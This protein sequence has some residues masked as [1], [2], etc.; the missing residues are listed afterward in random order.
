MSQF[1]DFLAEQMKDPE[2]SAAYQRVSTEID[3]ELARSIQ[4]TPAH[5]L[6]HDSEIATL[7]RA[8]VEAAVKLAQT[9][10][11]ID[12]RD[13]WEANEEALLDSAKA[14]IAARELAEKQSSGEPDL[15]G[16]PPYWTG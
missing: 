3:R 2:F 1:K 7:E 11:H 8:V 16:Y 10:D 14:L 4:T 9:S 15:S 5:A 13:E 12:D 6:A